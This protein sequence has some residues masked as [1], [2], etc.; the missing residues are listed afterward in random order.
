M[1]ERGSMKVV[2]RIVSIILA[3]VLVAG[4]VN[5]VSTDSLAAG[6]KKT[7]TQVVTTTKQCSIWTKPN[8]DEKNRQKVVPAGYQITIIPTVVK[9]TKGD[10]KTFY[11]TAKG[12]YILCGCVD[13]GSGNTN[14]STGG[15]V[16]ASAVSCVINANNV[17]MSAVLASAP[18]S[19]DGMIYVYPLQ[20]F[21]NSVPATALPVGS[22]AASASPTI[23]FPYT[24]NYLYQKF[25]LAVKKGGK[26]EKL[27]EPQYIT[28]PEAVATNT[29]PRAAKTFAETQ[30]GSFTNLYLGSTALRPRDLKRVTQIMNNGMN[31]VLTNPYSRIGVADSHPLVTS[32]YMLNC[33]EAQGVTLIAQTVH[34]YAAASITD[35]WIIGNEVNVR[36]WNYMSFTSWEDYMKQY[37]QVFRVCYN[38][39]KSANAN[40]RVYVCIDQNWDRNRNNKHKEYYEYIDG[41]D[42]LTMFA[43]DMKKNGDIDWCVAQ[44][45]YTVPLT[46]AKFWDMSGC[47]D[48]KYMATQVNNG[49]MMSFQNLSV[50]T[51]FMQTKEMLTK[52]GTVRHILLS[53]IGISNAQGGDVQAAALYASFKAASSNPFIDGIIYLNANSGSV[54]T[55][56]GS[57][58][59]L[60]YDSF[61][62]NPSAYDGWAKQVIGINKWNQVLK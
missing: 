25:V 58:A 34:N 52:A 59:Q 2:K 17:V 18:A 32:N 40:A 19:D 56:L 6:K 8:T 4:L 21:E 20:V 55:T 27:C 35:D 54:N 23:A 60:V 41:K 1:K 51:N 24:E 42:F 30:A 15:N 53:E 61:A 22:V 11:Q 47:K 12:A 39:I 16:S 31:Q 43:A 46:Y 33:A 10:G 49:A 13:L 45:P 7:T 14:P 38:A 57:K 44:H 37:E 28:N 5:V 3:L 36:M 48:G 50:L 62:T 29:H 26:I 9:S